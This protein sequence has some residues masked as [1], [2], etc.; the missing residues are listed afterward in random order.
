MNEMLRGLQLVGE[1]E[2][3]V[4]WEKVIDRSYLPNDL[5]T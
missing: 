4:D 2:G 1:V 5:R 3:N